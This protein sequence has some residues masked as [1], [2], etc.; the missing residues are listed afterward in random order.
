ML[1]QQAVNGI[2][3]GGVYALEAV[4]FGIV[5]N[6]LKF[7]NFS[8]SGLVALCAYVGYY[9]STR[10]VHSFW[11]TLILTALVGAGLGMGIERLVFRPIRLKDR[12]L[13]YFF[14]NSITVA[15]L[16][17]QFLSAMWGSDYYPY[18]EFV[19][20]AAINIGS[21][22]V[23]QAYVMMMV[24]SA[25]V[26]IILTLFL[27]LTRTGIAI[28]AA[29]SDIRTLALM[30]IK[31][32][33]VIAAT[34]AIAGLLGGFTGYFLGMSYT[35][36]PFIGSLIL[37]GIIASIIGGMGSLGGGVAAGFILGVAESFLIAEIGASLT[38]VVINASI[39]LL[40]LVRPQGIAGKL[41]TIKA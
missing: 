39:I 18:P 19:Q 33:R 20:K 1:A 28:R 22:V 9:L 37:K 36:S 26:L 14:V 12:P 3:L 29:S 23:S 25:A 32:D 7:S 31:A 27:R 11:P 15:M 40:L 5:F 16:V 35:V 10:V 30:G 8:H 2:S 34:F 41:H 17:Q 13:T 38:P 4:G 21:L 6:I 24:I